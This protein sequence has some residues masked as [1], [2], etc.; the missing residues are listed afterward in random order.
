MGSEALENEP[1]CRTIPCNGC[2]VR[3]HAQFA[4]PL[5]AMMEDSVWSMLAMAENAG[6]MTGLDSP[7]M[8]KKIVYGL[9]AG[10]AKSF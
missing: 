2:A 10:D 7:D 3:C 9:T 1:P 4:L 6:G 5:T 8:M